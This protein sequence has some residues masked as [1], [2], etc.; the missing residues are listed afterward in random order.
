MPKSAVDRWQERSGSMSSK[1][2][3]SHTLR[4]ESPGVFWLPENPGL[5]V[6]GLLSTESESGVQ[7][8]LLGSFAPD[9]A[10]SD[11]STP[12][13]VVHGEL[14]RSPFPGA[15]SVTM[16]DAFSRKISWSSVGTKLE[17]IVANGTFAGDD[18]LSS[19]DATFSACSVELSGLGEWVRTRA[20]H[21]KTQPHFIVQGINPPVR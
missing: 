15:S 11:V 13:A 14:H 16:I 2:P 1:Q 8:E 7:L 5:R 20:V 4:F 10:F 3:E 21:V 19:R 6:S 12:Y 17:T 9:V 18:W